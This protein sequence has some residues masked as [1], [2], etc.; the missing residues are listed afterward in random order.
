M[1]EKGRSMNLNSRQK[2]ILEKLLRKYEGSKT[3]K[4][5]NSIRQTFSIVPTDVYPKYN[6]DFE[7]VNSIED[8]E[9]ELK[10]LES[11]NL[12]STESG[13][14]H[15]V[16]ILANTSDDYW[17]RVRDILGVKDKKLQHYTI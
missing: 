13:N 6:D 7:D 16:K 10:N 14:Q 15:V 1:V 8:F 2:L 11:E 5:E 4:G 3:Y 17:L 9:K 12:I